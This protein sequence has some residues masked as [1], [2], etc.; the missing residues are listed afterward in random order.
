M[1]QAQYSRAQYESDC[2]ETL[3][4]RERLERHPNLLFWYEQ[5]YRHQLGDASELKGKVILE[6]GS[7][8]SPLQRLVPTIVTSDIMELPHLDHVFDCHRIDQVSALADRSIDVIT[9]TNVLH[10]LKEPVQFLTNA[11]VKLKQ[12][13]RIIATEPYF[14]ALS[15]FIYKYI[16]HEPVDEKITRP[17][18]ETVAGPLASANII[19]PHLLFLGERN[20]AEPLRALYH[21][22][23]GD[24]RY[25][26]GL[27]Y[28]MTGGISRRLP[29]PPPV[30]RFLFAADAWVTQLCPTLVASFFTI[31]LTRK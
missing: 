29:I 18:L 13:G 10:H 26:S 22:S 11:A 6:I 17:E 14:S 27:S 16:H 19:L 15:R 24:I 30:Y 28:M 21:F 1:Q 20:W 5:L 8:S 31:T 12:G 4:N 9:L 23:R 7:G 3:R 2:A 25:F